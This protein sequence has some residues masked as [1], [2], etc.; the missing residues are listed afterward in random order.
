M[1]DKSRIKYLLKKYRTGTIL[2][3]EYEE[4]VAYIQDPSYNDIILNLMD[5]GYTVENIR[6]NTASDIDLS[7]EDIKQR[8]GYRKTSF[9][10]TKRIWYPAAALFV[11]FLM[12]IVFLQGNLFTPDILSVETATGERKNVALPDGSVVFLNAGSAIS[13]PEKFDRGVRKVILKGEGFFEVVHEEDRPFLVESKNIT[14]RVLGTSFNVKSYEGDASVKVSVATGKVMVAENGEN[15]T[16]RQKM[17]LLPNEQASYE[18]S[19]LQKN[20]VNISRLIAWKDNMLVF[21]NTPLS[22]AIVTLERWYGVNIDFQ[23]KTIDTSKVS[24]EFKSGEKLEEVLKTFQYVLDMDYDFVHHKEIKLSVKT[25]QKDQMSN[26]TE[27]TE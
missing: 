21:H 14:T 12:S 24:G 1:Y 7:F 11:L 16:A 18:N 13:Y 6:N 19:A 3:S 2:R 15:S 10:R 8:I 17:T 23:D 26:P 5:E 25:S 22:E 4:L 27:K 9:F 20:E